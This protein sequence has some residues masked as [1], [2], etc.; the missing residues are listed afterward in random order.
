MVWSWQVHKGFVAQ[1]ADVHGKV[2][3]SS[4]LDIFHDQAGFYN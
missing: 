1:V 3:L 4:F 2:Q